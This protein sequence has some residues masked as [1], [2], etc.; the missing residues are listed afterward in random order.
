MRNTPTP[1]HLAAAEERLGINRIGNAILCYAWGE[2]DRPEVCLAKTADDVRRFLILEAF[3]DDKDSTIGEWMQELA[4]WDWRED[5]K[6]EWTFEI[7]G[8][9]LEDV[10][11]DS[12]C[13]EQ[14]VNERLLTKL[15]EIVKDEVCDNDGRGCPAIGQIEEA[16]SAAGS[17]PAVTD[18]DDVRRAALFQLGLGIEHAEVTGVE[19]GESVYAAHRI[20]ANNNPAGTAGESQPAVEAQAHD[21]INHWCERALKAEKEVAELRALLVRVRETMLQL[22]GMCYPAPTSTRKYEIFK[23]VDAALESK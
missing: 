6:L 20:L 7:G 21:R 1:R 13:P 10:A 19:L 3:G 12:H 15:R 22:N 9:R 5:G 14:G 23:A 4:A 16:I 11:T 17:Q 2:T 8:V 18:S